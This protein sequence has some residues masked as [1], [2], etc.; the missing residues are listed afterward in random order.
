MSWREGSS[1]PIIFSEHH[2]L[3][4]FAEVSCAFAAPCDDASS[5]DA[6]SGTVVEGLEDAETRNEPHQSPEKEEALLYLLHCFVH[7]NC[8]CKV[9]CQEYTKESEAD[10]SLHISVVDGGGGVCSSMPLEVHYQFIYRM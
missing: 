9:L 10:H 2:S 7:M 1:P 6:L 8:P 4:S 3:Q 5:E